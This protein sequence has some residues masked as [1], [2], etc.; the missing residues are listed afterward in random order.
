M[1]IN[2]HSEN[3]N[4]YVRLCIFYSLQCFGD[5]FKRFSSTMKNDTI[6]EID[7]KVCRCISHTQAHSK[8]S[9]DFELREKIEFYAVLHPYE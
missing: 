5:V 3:E 8:K 1:V 9:D 7:S 6:K 2:E 4:Y